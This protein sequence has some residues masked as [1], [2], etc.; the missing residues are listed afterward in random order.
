MVGVL[1][2][3]CGARAICCKMSI[4]GSFDA[5]SSACLVNIRCFESVSL[6]GNIVSFYSEA[7]IR[8]SRKGCNGRI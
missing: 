5:Y 3:P 8:H 4:Q 2:N 6:L 7:D 1:R